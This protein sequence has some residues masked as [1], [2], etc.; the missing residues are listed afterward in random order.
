M[1]RPVWHSCLLLQPVLPVSVSCIFLPHSSPLCLSA[2]PSLHLTPSYLPALSTSL[3]PTSLLSLLPPYVP[4]T[5]PFIPQSLSNK[6]IRRNQTVYNNVSIKHWHSI[7]M[8]T[9]HLHGPGNHS[10]ELSSPWK[11]HALKRH[12]L[13]NFEAY[14]EPVTIRDMKE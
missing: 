12:I 3:L 8:T 1:T 14:G 7:D 4:S 6:H 9:T 13:K 11:I 5:F 10:M 2:S